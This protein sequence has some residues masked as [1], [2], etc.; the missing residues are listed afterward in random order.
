MASETEYGFEGTIKGQVYSKANSRKLVH[1]GGKPMFIKSDGA[2]AFET[3]AILQLQALYRRRKPLSG[4][5]VIECTIY[6]PNQ[7][8]DLDA[9]L[10]FDV[11]QKAGVI[12]NDRQLREQH[13]FHAIDKLN[14]RVEIAIWNR[15]Q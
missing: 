4:D 5:L 11:L 14:P 15:E 10:V 13:L 1:H 9:S 12:V 2:R 3:S 6:Y 7:R 8:Q